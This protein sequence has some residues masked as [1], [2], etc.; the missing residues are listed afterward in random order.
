MLT[1]HDLKHYVDGCK[2]D[3][4]VN[5]TCELCRTYNTLREAKR[6]LMGRDAEIEQLRAERD[7]MAHVTV[8]AGVVPGEDD[9]CRCEECRAV[10]VK[11]ADAGYLERVTDR[12]WEERE[13]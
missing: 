9:G 6:M 13:G 7:A 2:C 11:M 10:A 4:S 3:P 5:H 1:I 12:W 8:E